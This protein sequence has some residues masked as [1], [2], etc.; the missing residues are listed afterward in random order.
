MPRE[1]RSPEAQSYHRWYKQALW[2]KIRKA[3]LNKAPLCERHLKRNEIVPANTVN[4]KEPHKGEW[5]K[6]AD[7]DNLESVCASCHS[8]DIQSEERGGGTKG[9]DP[10]GTPFDPSHHWNL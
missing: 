3:Q 9:S 6:F 4:H 5:T 1:Q 2:Q 7:S 8:S 10:S